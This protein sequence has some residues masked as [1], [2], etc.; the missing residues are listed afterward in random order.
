MGL[1]NLIV[2]DSSQEYLEELQRRI[3]N[4]CVNELVVGALEIGESTYMATQNREADSFS[5]RNLEGDLCFGS[6]HRYFGD[7]IEIDGNWFLLASQEELE[8]PLTLFSPENKSDWFG[9]IPFKEEMLIEID[10]KAFLPEDC[11]QGVALYSLDGVIRNLLGTPH[12]RM[13]SVLK[14]GDQ[15]FLV[16][17]E[18][19]EGLAIYSIDGEK[20]FGNQFYEISGLVKIEGELLLEAREEEN[21]NWNIYSL[22]GSYRFGS[23][24]PHISGF[25][26]AS[27]QTLLRTFHEKTDSIR[28]YSID[29]QNH[30]F[31]GPYT[32]IKD[33][34][35]VNGEDFL[36]AE[37]DY[38]EMRLYSENGEISDLFGGPHEVTLGLIEVDNQ[39]Y[40]VTRNQEQEVILYSI[41]G[42][43]NNLFGELRCSIYCSDSFDITEI[44][45]HLFLELTTS[46]D[47]EDPR[48]GPVQVKK[49]FEKEKGVCFG[50][51][52]HEAELFEID[53]QPFV[54]GEKE[55]WGLW[56]ICSLDGKN[57]LF[58]G[59]PRQNR[60]AS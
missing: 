31:R 34:V 4:K 9:E 50:G 6:P 17:E 45:E 36:I 58:G 43:I 29:G 33:V 38:G 30:W 14:L 55:K 7:F 46:L 52:Y 39:P 13:N 57:D 37:K 48:E 24:H 40:L 54:K 1:E 35:K 12:S 59:A 56:E 20:C 16:V 10:G 27:G 23:P 44:G 5:F 18:G 28:L 25:I 42:Q 19:T 32:S 41:D 8:P 22:D 26:E 3:K 2:C 51:L 11:Q 15:Q 60:R 49:I 53:G 47:T 21:E